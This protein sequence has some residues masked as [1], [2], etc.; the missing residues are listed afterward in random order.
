M[1][2]KFYRCEHCGNFITFL[3]N[4]GARPVCCGDAMS[5]VPVNTSDSAGEKHIPT[6]VRNGDR[7]VVTIGSI[8]HP[9]SVMH[10]INWIALETQDGLYIRQLEPDHDPQTEFVLSTGDSIKNVYAF[11]NI[12]GLWKLSL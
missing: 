10:H 6:L 7:V 1:N 11:C 5:D 4:S 12:H 3:Y 2:V 8:P 9:M